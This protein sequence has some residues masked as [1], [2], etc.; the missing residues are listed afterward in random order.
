MKTTMNFRKD[1]MA[2][3][4][5]RRSRK[6]QP[7]IPIEHTLLGPCVLIERRTTESNNAVLVTEF[8]DEAT[9]TFLAAPRFWMTP[10]ILATIPMTKAVV[11]NEPMV[12]NDVVDEVELELA[13]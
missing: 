10:L 12:E 7:K 2:T 8:P 3:K 6:K 5:L 11:A 4:A 1:R 9:R 13:A